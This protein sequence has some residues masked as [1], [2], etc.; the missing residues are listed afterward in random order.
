MATIEASE[1]GDDAAEIDS[2]TSSASFRLVTTLKYIFFHHDD[3][4]QDESGGEIY[5]LIKRWKAI[6]A[7]LLD[8]HA[9]RLEDAAGALGWADTLPRFDSKMLQAQIEAAATEDAAESSNNGQAA[10][11]PLQRGYARSRRTRVL[12]SRGGSLSVELGPVDDSP[13]TGSALASQIDNYTNNPFLSP[14]SDL[15]TIPCSTSSS[16]AP[17]SQVTLDTSPTPA[18]SFFTV[19]KTTHRPAHDDARSRAGLSPTT[20]PTAREVLLFNGAG[21]VTEASHSSVYFWRDGAW[22]A[23]GGGIRSVTRC[24]ALERGWCGEGVVRKEDVREGEVLWLSNAVRGFF[25]GVVR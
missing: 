24:Y 19:H 9:R 17:M 23:P 15:S 16:S 20:V 13:L 10:P 6:N 5:D 25:P 14:S 4:Q 22:V 7:R 21:E 2:I 12:V 1:N 18:H 11:P 3:E 8:L